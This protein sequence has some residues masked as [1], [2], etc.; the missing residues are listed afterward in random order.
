MNIHPDNRTM[1]ELDMIG[2]IVGLEFDRSEFMARPSVMLGL[3]PI[4]DGDQWSVLYGDNLQDGVCGFGDTPDDAMLDFDKN[5]KG[6]KLG[7]KK[8]GIMRKIIVDVECGE[9]ECGECEYVNERTYGPGRYMCN[10]FFRPC[11][12]DD[13]I[14]LPA[15]LAAEEEYKRLKEKGR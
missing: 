6:Q 15:C 14:R 2:R 12:E 13:P 7:A 11:G 3:V 10:L 9:T 4:P 5:W 8:G 1:Y